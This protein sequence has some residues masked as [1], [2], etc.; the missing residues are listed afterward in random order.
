MLLSE[1]MARLQA[2]MDEIVSVNEVL[3]KK[4]IRPHGRLDLAAYAALCSA[5]R[6][7]G[8]V[9]EILGNRIA[10]QGDKEVARS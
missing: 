8:M 3:A 7:V 10:G 5:T 4:A 2:A 6:E 1:A 9:H